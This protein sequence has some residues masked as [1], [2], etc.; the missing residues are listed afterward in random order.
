M[1]ATNLQLQIEAMATMVRVEG[2]KA[3]NALHI[4]RGDY[5]PYGESDFDS[6]AC[7]LDGIMQAVSHEP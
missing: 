7:Q 2:M 3:E 5:P 6:Y 1:N 4:A